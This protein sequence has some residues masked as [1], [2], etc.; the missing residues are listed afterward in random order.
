MTYVKKRVVNELFEQYLSRVAE[1]VFDISI[2]SVRST[3]AGLST[4]MLRLND[5]FDLD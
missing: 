1:V 2:T 4:L 5:V 3:Q